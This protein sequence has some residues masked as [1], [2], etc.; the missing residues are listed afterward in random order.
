MFNSWKLYGRIILETVRATSCSQSWSIQLRTVL[1]NSEIVRM[2]APGCRSVE[3][4]KLKCSIKCSW[5]QI[6]GKQ[7]PSS[8]TA[9]LGRLSAIVTA[10]RPAIS[11]YCNCTQTYKFAPTVPHQSGNEM[12]SFE[13]STDSDFPTVL[14]GGDLGRGRRGELGGSN[15]G[16]I[17]VTKR[18][19]RNIPGIPG[20]SSDHLPYLPTLGPASFLLLHEIFFSLDTLSHEVILATYLDLTPAGISLFASNQNMLSAH[21]DQVEDRSDII[22]HRSLLSVGRHR[23]IFPGFDGKATTQQTA[24]PRWQT[25]ECQGGN[26]YTK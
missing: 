4:L 21:K 10:P 17:E 14:L 11:S 3:V 26:L 9:V 5:L 20:H 8:P 13:Q 7:L 1:L 23:L 22:S 12:L 19:E 16:V 24:N 6:S 25:V 2:S 15:W 18:V